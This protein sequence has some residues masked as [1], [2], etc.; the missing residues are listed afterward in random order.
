[1]PQVHADFIKS[2]KIIREL[3]L[4]FLRNEAEFDQE[5]GEAFIH[6]SLER[7]IVDFI[8]GMTDRYAFRLFEKLF[9]PQPWIIV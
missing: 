5:A 6:G 8:A 7:R 4:H 3:Y 1:L 2:A 9:L